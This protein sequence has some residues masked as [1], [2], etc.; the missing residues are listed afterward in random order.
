VLESTA[1]RCAGGLG[2]T[3]K[4]GKKQGHEL[5][6]LLKTTRLNRVRVNDIPLYARDGL[7]FGPQDGKTSERRF[8]IMAFVTGCAAP[9]PYTNNYPVRKTQLAYGRQLFKEFKRPLTESIIYL[10]L[11][12]AFQILKMCN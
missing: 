2:F 10:N 12:C 7:N 4:G 6:Q 11:T 3:A 8:A 5:P 1:T 9:V